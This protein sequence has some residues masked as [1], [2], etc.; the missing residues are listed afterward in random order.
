MV[1]AA[2]CRRSSAGPVSTAGVPDPFPFATRDLLSLPTTPAMIMTMESLSFLTP[3]LLW[4]MSLASIPIIIHLLFRRRFRR[5]ER[6][7]MHY[8]KLSIQRNRRRVRLEQLLLLLLRALL[9]LLLFFFIARPVIHAAGLG[10]W[11]GGSSRTSQV[12]LLDDSLSMDYREGGRSAW[13]RAKELAVKLLENIGPKDRFTLVLASQPKQPL[14][15]EVEL[16]NPDDAIQ[17]ISELKPSDTFAAWEPVMQAMD[18]LIIS[19]SYP[20]REPT[21][22]TDLRRSGWDDTVG[23]IGSRWTTARL[24]MRIFDVGSERTANVALEDLKQLDRLAMVGNPTHYEAVVYNAS[25]R[26]LS[27]LDGTWTIDG[28]P[29]VVRL[30]T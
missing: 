16:A 3:P 17:L 4:G 29:S 7:P 20:I 15:R 23:P 14:L 26:E 12:L 5:V 24:E 22:V 10:K 8:L 30:P 9:F 13:D 25:E 2:S 11:L 18:E 19:G 1:A 28:K 6:A 27:S 21:L